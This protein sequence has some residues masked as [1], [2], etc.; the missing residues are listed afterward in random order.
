MLPDGVAA[1]M[2]AV[3]R[4]FE[5]KRLFTSTI[6]GGMHLAVDLDGNASQSRDRRLPFARQKERDAEKAKWNPISTHHDKWIDFVDSVCLL[7]ITTFVA[8]ECHE[9]GLWM[10]LEPGDINVLRHLDLVSCPRFSIVNLR[11]YLIGVPNPYGPLQ[12]SDCGNRLLNN[13]V[14]V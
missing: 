9:H 5:R 6:T 11:R 8:R 13:R 12:S 7:T 2:E 3:G 4:G 10:L 1:V 14:R